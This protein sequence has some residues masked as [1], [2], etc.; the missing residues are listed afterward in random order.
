VVEIENE[1]EDIREFACEI[2]DDEV[3]RFIDLNILHKESASLPLDMFLKG[4]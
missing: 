4:I 1:N 3:V 2:N